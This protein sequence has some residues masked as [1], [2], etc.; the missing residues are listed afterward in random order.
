MVPNDQLAGRTL[1]PKGETVPHC[2][3]SS[4]SSVSRPAP[5]TVRYVKTITVRLGRG[6]IQMTGLARLTTGYSFHRPHRSIMLAPETVAKTYKAQGD[7]G[8]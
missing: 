2:S 1:N 7:P 5:V 3:V 6:G 8:Q 4:S